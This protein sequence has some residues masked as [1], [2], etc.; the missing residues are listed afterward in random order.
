MSF[1]ETTWMKYLLYYI[2]ARFNWNYYFYRISPRKQN[3]I[4]LWSSNFT[5]HLK[6]DVWVGNLNCNY[7]TPVND[8]QFAEHLLLRLHLRVFPHK[9]YDFNRHLK[10]TKAMLTLINYVV[11]WPHRDE[12]YN[13]IYTLKSEQVFLFERYSQINFVR[14]IID[15]V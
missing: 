14:K 7:C 15:K 12:K 3:N 1:N 10:L 5:R 6:V 4:M 13:I 9:M 8:V 2:L 11:E